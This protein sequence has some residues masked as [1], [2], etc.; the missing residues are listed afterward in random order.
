VI[1][2]DPLASLLGTKP[3]ERGWRMQFRFEPSLYWQYIWNPRLAK[4]HPLPRLL[5]LSSIQTRTRASTPFL[6]TSPAKLSKFPETMAIQGSQSS[7]VIE[8]LD[9]LASLTAPPKNE[10]KMERLRREQRE[11]FA[12]LISDKID[13]GLNGEKTKAANQTPDKKQVR[14]LV[15]GHRGSGRLFR[16]SSK[17]IF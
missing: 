7:Q 13:E 16:F 12:K 15:L 5:L 8:P 10:S 4:M 2:V 17:F 3:A 1:S 11:L 6:S 9:P 14:V